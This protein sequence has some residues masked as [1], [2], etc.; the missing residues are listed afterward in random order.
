MGLQSI[1]KKYSYLL[2]S[3]TT[4]GQV[5]VWKVFSGLDVV[6]RSFLFFGGVFFENEDFL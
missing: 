4:F 5:S 1:S 6:L 2:P 3:S